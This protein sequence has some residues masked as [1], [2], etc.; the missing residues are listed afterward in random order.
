MTLSLGYK[1][2]EWG[3]IIEVGKRE[4]LNKMESQILKEKYYDY[5]IFTTLL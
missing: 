5:N 4:I 3:I 2:N 1:A